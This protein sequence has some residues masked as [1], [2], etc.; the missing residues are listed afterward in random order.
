MITMR[1]KVITTRKTRLSHSIGT[2]V[3]G[4]WCEYLEVPYMVLCNRNTLNVSVGTCIAFV[5][6]T[7]CANI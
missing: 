5:R 3:S 1:G 4:E 7:K 6:E 2:N